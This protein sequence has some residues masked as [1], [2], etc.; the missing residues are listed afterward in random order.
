MF[1]HIRIM[2]MYVEVFYYS[3]GLFLEGFL[4]QIRKWGCV[5]PICN[6]SVYK[7]IYNTT[8]FL[9]IWTLDINY[10]IKG[11]NFNYT[12]ICICDVCVN[13][14]DSLPKWLAVVERAVIMNTMQHKQAL[15]RNLP[16]LR[17]NVYVH[18]H[19]CV[20]TCTCT[21]SKLLYVKQT[22]YFGSVIKVKHI[23]I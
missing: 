6:M 4:L 21:I 7:L 18:V 16:V 13:Q 15:Y 12:C 10:V 17:G 23:L 2:Y 11:S 9:E 5:W 19:M 8:I 22:F 14:V 20:Y 1:V 3:V